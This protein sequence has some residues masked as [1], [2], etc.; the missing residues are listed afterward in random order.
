MIVEHVYLYRRCHSYHNY[1]RRHLV[2]VLVVVIVVF[3]IFQHGGSRPM[4]GDCQPGS[5]WV[6]LQRGSSQVRIVA[7]LQECN[8]SS[9]LPVGQF[10]NCNSNCNPQP[11]HEADSRSPEVL[12]QQEHPP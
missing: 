8:P 3:I 2:I 6:R 10:G 9:D 12:P 11:L 7:I 4:P 1:R 5:L